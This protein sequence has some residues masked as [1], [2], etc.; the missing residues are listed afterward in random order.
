MNFE[1]IE[2]YTLRDNYLHFEESKKI[3]DKEIVKLIEYLYK[4]II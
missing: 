3:Y 4:K 2:I 1:E